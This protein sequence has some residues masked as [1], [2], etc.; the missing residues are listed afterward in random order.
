MR[1][2]IAEGL[3]RWHRRMAA[4]VP[5][6]AVFFGTAALGLRTMENQGYRLDTTNPQLDIQADQ[7]PTQVSTALH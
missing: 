3:A 2:H 6:A 4:I 1:Y 7:T 5:Q